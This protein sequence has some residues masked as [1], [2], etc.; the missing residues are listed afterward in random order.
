MSS[1]S[2]YT[3]KKENV[4]A[5]SLPVPRIEAL[6]LPIVAERANMQKPHA[7][8]DICRQSA[9]TCKLLVIITYPQKAS[10]VCLI[11]D[12]DNETA[13]FLCVK[14]ERQVNASYYVVIPSRK[15]RDRASTDRY[16]TT[17]LLITIQKYKNN[18]HN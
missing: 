4:R 16:D 9:L 7:E 14:K 18:Q 2:G 13:R 1:Q 3:T 10:T 8:Y 12:Y 17:K 11:L 5:S 6:A 15:A